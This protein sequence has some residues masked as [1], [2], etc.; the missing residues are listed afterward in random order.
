MSER[1]GK[2]LDTVMTLFDVCLEV[3][4]PARRLPGPLGIPSTLLRNNY[5]AYRPTEE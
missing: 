3:R 1:L 4:G 5:S 2:N